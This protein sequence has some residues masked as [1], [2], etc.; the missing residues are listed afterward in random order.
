MR[1][2][3]RNVE[4][5]IEQLKTAKQWDDI[6]RVLQTRVAEAVAEAF[7]RIETGASETRHAV[8]EVLAD[9]MSDVGMPSLGAPIDV[10]TLWSAK[11]IDIRSSRGGKVVGEALTG[12][13]GAQSGMIMFGMMG[14]FL[15]AGIGVL[16]ASNPVTL[17]L[18]A[19][20]GGMQLADAQ[21]R[22]V[23]QRRQQA[24]VN[25]RQFSDDVQFEV[26]N[27]IG[28]VIR[29]VQRTIRDDFT[30][31][32]AELHATYAETARAATESIA[33]DSADRTQRSD[34]L[35]SADGPALA[36]TSSARRG[37]RSVGVTGQASAVDQVLRLCDIAIG[38]VHGTTRAEEV[39]QIRARLHGPLRVAIAGRVKAGKSTL[40]NALVGERLAATDAGECTRLVTWYQDGL[41]YDV[42]AVGHDGVG[43]TLAFQRIDGALRF[44]LGSLDPSTIERVVVTWPSSALRDVTLI[45]TPGLAS[46][47]DSNSLR[48]R[49][50]LAMGENRPSDADAVIY[51]MRHLHR[52]DAEFLGAFLD[53]SVAAASPINAVS[54]LSRADEIGACRLD[55]MG[56]AA[57]I[58]NRYQSDPIVRT[59]CT[60]V[61]PIAGLI[62]ETGL[63]L[64]EE[65][66]AA[67]RLLATTPADVLE[68]MLLSADGFCDGG[69]SD[70]TIELRRG[71]LDRLGLFGLRLLTE[72]IRAGRCT[73]AGDMARHLVATSALADLRALIADRFL[74]RARVLQPGRRWWHC[75][76]W[77]AR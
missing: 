20:F 47:D 49:E 70:L 66:A 38:M 28:E 7:V 18:G 32:I 14:Q 11:P 31:R 39:D 1:K 69:S 65:E 72:E 60:H 56:S 42:Q 46:I 43:H 15:P 29:T 33:R 53:R 25:A 57:R 19:V 59:L 26:G 41:T 50:F 8:L 12:L 36:T 68:R 76:T 24:R 5:E 48:T 22:K 10:S 62:A 30:Q 55:A 3:T 64:R 2:I 75:A 52:R 51:L 45:D 21:K 17:G 54:V 67:L 77:H 63:T 23:A 74:P 61:V 34:E 40:L 27:T 13:R 4:E 44:D 73:T 6:S 58:A 16:L 71:L 35:R 37:R 9:D